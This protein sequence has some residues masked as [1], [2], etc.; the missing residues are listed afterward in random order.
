MLNQ[1]LNDVANLQ[2]TLAASTSSSGPTPVSGNQCPGSPTLYLNQI[3]ANSF[4]AGDLHCFILNATNGTNYSIIVG[5]NFDST[6]RLYDANW[7]ELYYSDDNGPGANPMITFAAAYTGIYYAV[8]DGYSDSSNGYYQILVR[9]QPLDPAFL[10][11][12]YIETNTVVRGVIYE[13]TW[14]LIPSLNYQ[15]RG[16]LYYYYNGIAGQTIQIDVYGPSIGS[17]IDPYVELYDTFGNLLASDD[18]SGTDYDS[19]LTYSLPISSGYY[20]L[21]RSLGDR[22]GDDTTYFFD[23]LVTILP[24]P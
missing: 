18:D 7:N 2:S 5:G 21:V 24:T 17:Q 3:Y 12:Y 16:I 6:M 9:N 13:D 8:L 15:A 23:L 4:A 11:E 1:S 19:R 20:I 10:S 22:F 14:V